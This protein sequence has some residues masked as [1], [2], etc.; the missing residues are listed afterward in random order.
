M[1]GQSDELSG[2]ALATAGVIGLIL[3]TVGYW[4]LSIFLLP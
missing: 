3:A 4:A 2:R 1:N